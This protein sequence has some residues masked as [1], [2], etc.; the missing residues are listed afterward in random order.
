MGITYIRRQLWF[1]LLCRCTACDAIC[2]HATKTENLRLRKS[3]ITASRIF[4]FKRPKLSIKKSPFS[5]QRHIIPYLAF[6][7]LNQR[8]KPGHHLRQHAE[9]NRRYPNLYPWYRQAFMTFEAMAA[10]DKRSSCG[11][12]LGLLLRLATPPLR[13]NSPAGGH[14]GPPLRLA[15]ARY[16][17]RC[18]QT[19]Y[20][21]SPRVRPHWVAPA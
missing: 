18:E 10:I 6:F 12:P 14:T 5:N 9:F 2:D 17:L 19:G 13:V 21:R 15:D 4:L 1:R 11:R 7:R 3:S 20:A 8:K 16:W